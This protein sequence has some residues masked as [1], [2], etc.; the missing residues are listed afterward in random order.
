MRKVIVGIVALFAGLASVNPVAHAD[1]FNPE[2]QSIIMNT[3]KNVY[4]ASMRVSCASGDSYRVTEGHRSPCWD[5]DHVRFNYDKRKV[6]V[7]LPGLNIRY[8]KMTSPGTWYTLP[9]GTN[10][11]AYAWTSSTSDL[12]GIGTALSKW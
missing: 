11:W 12:P 3:V 2:P 4:G 6:A 1:N 7:Q 9:N 5:T 10:V 8:Y